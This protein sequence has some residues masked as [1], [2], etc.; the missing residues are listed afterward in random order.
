MRKGWRWKRNLLAPT[1]IFISISLLALPGFGQETFFDQEFFSLQTELL[2]STPEVPLGEIFGLKPSIHSGEERSIAALPRNPE[3]GAGE[4]PGKWPLF[5]RGGF[6]FSLSTM[7][8]PLL[9]FDISRPGMDEPGRLE[10]DRSWTAHF[11]DLPSGDS[12]Q[13]FGEIFQPELQLGI[14]F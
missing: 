11:F 6:V 14:E 2:P 3:I 4:K 9:R 1:A 5:T 13:Y 7:R 12:L 10:R 8:D